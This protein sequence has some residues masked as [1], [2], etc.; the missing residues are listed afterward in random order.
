MIVARKKPKAWEDEILETHMR[1]EQ[2]A[3]KSG[4]ERSVIFTLWKAG[5]LHPIKIGGTNFYP[6]ESVQTVKDYLARPKNVKPEGDTLCWE[7][8][9]ATGGCSWS[10]KLKPVKGWTVEEGSVSVSVKSCPKYER[11]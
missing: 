10:K 7:C 5:E 6:P 1:I 3:R 2:L 9:N 8:R 4:C 11:G